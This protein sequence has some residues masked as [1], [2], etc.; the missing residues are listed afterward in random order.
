LIERINSLDAIII[1]LMEDEADTSAPGKLI[2][3]QIIRITI[4][5]RAKFGCKFGNG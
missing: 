1:E 3:S 4:D 2:D 5:H